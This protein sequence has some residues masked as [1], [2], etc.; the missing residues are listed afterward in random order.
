[1]SNKRMDGESI[2]EWRDRIKSQKR[3]EE[4][5]YTDEISPSIV[6]ADATGK[7]RVKLAKQ[8]YKDNIANKEALQSELTNSDLIID[9]NVF[10]DFAHRIINIKPDQHYLQNIKKEK[11]EYRSKSFLGIGN[12]SGNTLPSK[13]YRWW[14]RHFG[15]QKK[16]N[17][18]FTDTGTDIIDL[19]NNTIRLTPTSTHKTA[20]FNEFVESRYPSVHPAQKYQNG[21]ISIVGDLYKIPVENLHIYGGIE[22]G[23]F[24]LDSLHNF[25]PNTTIFPA[26]NVKSNIPQI[27]KLG[28]SAFEAPVINTNNLDLARLLLDKTVN[29]KYKAAAYGLLRK[30]LYPEFSHILDHVIGIDS[31]NYESNGLNSSLLENHNAR[32]EYLKNNPVSF[33]DLTVISS[34]YLRPHW[35]S[36]YKIPYLKDTK[37]FSDLITDYNW[38]L[39]P[40]KSTSNWYY[41]EDKHGVKHPISKYNASILDNKMV[42]GN[43][44]GGI[45]VGRFQDISDRQLDSLNNYLKQNPSWLIRPDLGGFDLYRLDSPTLKQ[46][47]QQYSETIDPSDPNVYTVG[48]TE[49]NKLWNGKK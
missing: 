43:P 2:K 10:D 15:Y 12:G 39:D 26:R 6:T 41:F 5:V 22:D 1:M 19:R 24:K 11:D 17:P 47:L 36:K 48:T 20:L 37:W 46:Y 35:I 44:S 38:S 33:N 30:D 25:K 21:E 7:G 28:V 31:K 16:Y 40:R 8:Q 13:L 14:S 3:N 49:D 23:K 45:F 9:Q 42:I 32:K 4:P 18:L 34:K 29:S 27:Y